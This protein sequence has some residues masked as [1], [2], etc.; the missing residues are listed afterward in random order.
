MANRMYRYSLTCDADG[1]WT[2]SGMTG[3]AA[4]HFCKLAAALDF[5][6]KDAQG[7]AADIELLAD[8]LYMFVHQTQGWPSRICAPGTDR[9][10]ALLGQMGGL[11]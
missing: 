6:R 5:A 3:K 2:L 7:H 4:L 11:S 9:R 10:A 8:G 1:L